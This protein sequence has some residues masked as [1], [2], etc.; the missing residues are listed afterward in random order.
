MAWEMFATGVTKLVV[1]IGS[2]RRMKGRMK[3]PLPCWIFWSY[4]ANAQ[5]VA[6]NGCSSYA[7]AE[8]AED[9]MQPNAEIGNVYKRPITDEDSASIA[10][11]LVQIF[12]PSEKAASRAQSSDDSL[13]V[14]TTRNEAAALSGSD[15]KDDREV[16]V[17]QLKGDF[18]SPKPKLKDSH[19]DVASDQ[20]AVTINPKTYRTLD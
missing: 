7:M 12:A 16:L 2:L 1:G 17:F 9:S 6:Q 14:R 19:I 8:G 18:A 11:E 4:G 5:V 13:F 15:L 20:L 3:M 10:L